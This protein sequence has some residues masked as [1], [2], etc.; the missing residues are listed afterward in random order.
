MKLENF[1]SRQ[2]CSDEWLSSA[3][4]KRGT[5]T[6]V[7]S[8]PGPFCRRMNYCQDENEINSLLH[9]FFG[10]IGDNQGII[11]IA[12]RLYHQTGRG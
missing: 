2:H 9:Y 7:I 12:D 8:R 5:K 4:I 3:D 1:F 6:S 10:I 11:A